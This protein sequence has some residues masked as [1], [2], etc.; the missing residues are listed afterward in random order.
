MKPVLRPFEAACFDRSLI[1]AG[2]ESIELMRRAAHGL[3]EAAKA[4]DTAGANSFTALCGSG[5]NGGDG[6][7]ALCEL[8]EAGADCCA[9]TLCDEA[10]LSADAKWYLHLARRVGVRILPWPQPLK[11]TILIDALLG[12]GLHRPVEGD[13]LE[14]IKAMNNSGC[15]IIAADLPS[16]LN[17]E[18]GQVMGACVHADAT[19][20]FGAYKVGLLLG[21]G[22]LYAGE[23]TLC[24]LTEQ[25]PN[26]DVFLL[27]QEDVKALLP[28]RPLDSHK[29]KNGHALLC[30]GSERYVGAALLCA[31]SC[32]RGGSGLTTVALPASIRPALYAIPEV[33][34]V[35][36]GKSAW[37]EEACSDA[38]RLFRGKSALGLGCGMGDDD[39]SPLLKAALQTKLPMVLDADGLNCLSRHSE[40]YLLL[41]E[42]VVLT[43]HPREMSRLTGEATELIAAGPVQTARQYA[44][45]WG[46]VVLL[47]GHTSVISNGTRTVLN[48]TGNAGLA[49]GGS[50]DVLTGLITALLA[51]GLS[52]FDAACAGAYLLGSSAELALQLLQ[53]RALTAGDVIDAISRS[54]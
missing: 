26:S 42:K 54:I 12:T 43:P 34:S 10:H 13:Y 40:L 4:M 3:A 22:R 18:T 47:K 20:T 52:A 38:I 11:N 32:L 23:I 41:H 29:G 27:A 39:L 9:I 48:C 45:A 17:G 50:G 1:Q 16:G 53:L 8:T 24:P 37:D 31:K 14:A 46:C 19:V 49:K 44:K 5:N 51:Q 36:C 15:P 35:P 28:P 21:Q 2:V 30:V 6:F 25:E 33:M 7:A